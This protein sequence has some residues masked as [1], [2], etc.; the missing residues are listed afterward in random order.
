MSRLRSSWLSADL[1]HSG[2]VF[3]ADCV[4][5]SSHCWLLPHS[6]KSKPPC[7]CV[8]P[9]PCKRLTVPMVSVRRTLAFEVGPF[10]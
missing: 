6:Q 10:L 8:A 9:G 7:L 5:A 3:T 4:E 2:S 1:R